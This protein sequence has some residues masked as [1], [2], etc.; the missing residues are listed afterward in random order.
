MEILSCLVRHTPFHLAKK[1][2]RSRPKKLEGKSRAASK[3]GAMPV[4]K[5][6]WLLFIELVADFVREWQ[7]GLTMKASGR[8]AKHLASV[9]TKPSVSLQVLLG[10]I[11]QRPKGAAAAPRRLST[12]SP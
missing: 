11:G 12:Q 5:Q 4:F 7:C 10:G 6:A 3:K 8:H 2:S 1:D 9:D